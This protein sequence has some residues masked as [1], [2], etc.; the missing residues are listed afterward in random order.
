[1]PKKSKTKCPRSGCPITNT[2]EVIGDRWSLLIIR[3]LMI[4]NHHEFSQLRDSGE[5]I[6][7]NIL[8]DRL[9]TLAAEGIID[10]IKHPTNGTKKLYYLTK[11][12]KALLPMM[13]EMIMWG[14]EF[15][16]GSQAPAAK[17]KPV[18]ENGDKFMAGVLTE[19]ESWEKEYLGPKR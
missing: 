17:M 3:D 6:A 18:R 11:K 5:G 9:K 10:S 19:L 12:G 1:V 15:C 4:W 16:E 7:T 14:D 8:T 13:R 2:L